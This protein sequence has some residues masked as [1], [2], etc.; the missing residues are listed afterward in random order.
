MTHPEG[1]SLHLG[2]DAWAHPTL[3]PRLQP[4]ETATLYPG[5]PRRGDQDAITNSIRDL[6]LYAGIITQTSTG[7]VLVGNHRLKALIELGATRVPVDTVD[8]D[9]TRAAAIVAR[10]NHTSDLGSYDDS[11]LLAL[12]TADENVLALSG[13]LQEDVDA[14][15]RAA[16]DPGIPPEYTRRTD[17]LIY[18]PTAEEPPPVPSL[19]NRTKA[20]ALIRE[21]VE[22]DL[23]DEVRDFLIAAANRHLVFDY[24]RIAEWYAHA[25]PG[26]QRLMEASALVIP[27]LEDAIAHGFVRLSTRLAGILDQDL[28]EREAQDAA[29]VAYRA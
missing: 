7:H 11:D 28:H 1:A 12:L 29:G 5:N 21:V 4:I 3:E 2:G 27:D 26:V 24:A 20:N 17:S 22:A 9:D 8:V 19:V 16:D 23:P 25:E 14:L 15:R 6:G 13:Y 10:D 18:T